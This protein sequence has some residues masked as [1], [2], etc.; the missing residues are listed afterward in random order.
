MIA[1]DNPPARPDEPGGSCGDA[2]SG[3]IFAGLGVGRIHARHLERLAVV[4]VRQSNPQQV[5][6]HRE[7]AELQYG[8]AQ[9]AVELGWRRDRVLVIDEDQ[10][11]TAQTAEG[12]I[13]FQRLLAEVGLDHV[14]LVLGFQMS[15][16]A[17]SCKDWHQLLELCAIFG[18]LLSD[19][20]G[21]GHM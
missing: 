5:L 8:L 11:Q 3:S 17:R 2:D 6:N 13:G 20:D 15:R 4:Y 12:R 9:R 21:F 14:G 7:S 1:A 16:L 18:T 10:G 19:L